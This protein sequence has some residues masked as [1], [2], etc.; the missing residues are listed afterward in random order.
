MLPFT[1]AVRIGLR[2]C[3]CLLLC[4]SVF[5]PDGW[6]A[7]QQSSRRHSLIS[8]P[9][10]GL[11]LAEAN[12]PMASPSPAEVKK[13]HSLLPPVHR[14]AGMDEPS[15]DRTHQMSPP[16]LADAPPMGGSPSAGESTMNRPSDQPTMRSAHRKDLRPHP[17]SPFPASVVSRLAPPIVAAP[18]SLEPAI[19]PLPRP[20]GMSPDAAVTLEATVTPAMAG[21]RSEVPMRPGS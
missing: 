3:C 21:R 15:L 7:D 5:L 13:S 20:D 11:A 16:G 14:R 10:M 18:S 9:W 8:R 12:A 19:R 17:R 4:S 2:S 6:A 1:R